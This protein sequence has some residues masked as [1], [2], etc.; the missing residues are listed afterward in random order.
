MCASKKDKY[1]FATVGT[2]QF[3]GLV[4]TLLSEQIMQLLAAQGFSKL[5]IQLGRGP[6]PVLPKSPPLQIEWYR[7]KPSLEEDMRGASLVVSHAGAGSILEGMRLQVRMVVVVNDT[8]SEFEWS[9]TV[10]LFCL[11]TQL[12]TFVPS[13]LCAAVHN[14]QQELAEELHERRHLVA[15]TPNGLLGALRQVLVVQETDLLPMPSADTSTFATYLSS[16]L[17]V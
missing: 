7:F 12:S 3:E 5:M 8:L 14:H 2:T 1:A 6:E 4:A 15:T 13:W 10:L 11:C 16:A 9:R 17:G